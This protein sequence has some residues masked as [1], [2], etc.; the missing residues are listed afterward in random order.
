MSRVGTGPRVTAS[1]GRLDVEPGGTAELLLTV[2]NTAD[3]IDGFT[4]R[5]VGLPPDA[6]T[7]RPPL[8][9]L[10]P[11]AEGTIAVSVAVPATHPAGRHPVVVAL[12]SQHGGPAVETVDLDLAVPRRPAVALAAR[13]SVVRSRGRAEFAVEVAN[14]G[15]TPLELTCSAA[16]ADRATSLRFTPATLRLGPG[17]VATTLVTARAPRRWAGGDL[18]RAITAQVAGPDAE[19]SLPLTLRQ[20]PIVGRGLLTVLVLASIVALWAAAFLLGI[21]QVLGAEPAVKTAPASFFAATADASDEASGPAGAAE[22][23]TGEAPAGAVPKDGLLPPGVG[24]TVT[25]TVTGAASG[26]PV[27]QITVEALRRTRDGLVVVSSAASQADG[28]YTLAGLFPGEYLLRFGADGYPPVWYPAAPDDAGA[29][30]V[31]VAAQRTAEGTD[32]VVAGE[33]ASL[34]GTVD[35]GD[36]VEEVPATVTARPAWTADDGAAPA[37]YTATT[38]GDGSYT[39]VGLPAPGTY[40]LTFEADGYRPATVVEHVGGG[41]RRFVS[42]V[43]LATGDG[44][45]AGVVTGGGRPLGGVT[46]STTVSDEAVTAGT[47][48]VGEVGRFVLPGLPT[49]GTYVLTFTLDG[50]AAQTAVVEL[51]AGQAVTDL[52]V[53]L[54]GG[55]GTVTGTLLA[56]GG[57][58]LGGA[59][60]T[61]GGLAEPVTTTTLT[62]GAVGGFTVGGLA[63]GAY[64]LTFEHEGYQPQTVPVT[65]SGSGAAAPLTVTMLDGLGRVTGR[66]TDDDGDATAG[67]TVEV[68]DGATVW[69]TTSTGG[70]RYVVAEVPAGVYTVSVRVDG[71]VRASAVTE[72]EPAADAVANL[73]LEAVR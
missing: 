70:G 25:G 18:D 17:A 32:V 37:E 12:D 1:T 35:P 50:H 30:P 43:R 22:S 67:L 14:R 38:A 64:T 34:S 16:D 29:E 52:A 36:A 8:L 65:V 46:V 15:N 28:G 26:E 13:P 41:Q 6:V 23:T 3:V 19:A 51:A 4:V 49:P 66:V 27:G 54:T 24:G 56:P 45:I 72:V 71:R 7:A 39:L 63:P 5:A 9:S 2:T 62:D 10:F 44:Q 57:A 20:R 55:A 59:T 60:V 58:G 61:V 40:E 73:R 48:T 53:S 68:T 11:D 33:P 69:T 31:A 21:T 47:P 42:E